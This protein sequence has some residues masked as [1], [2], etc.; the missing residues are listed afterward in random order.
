MDH[1]LL[2]GLYIHVHSCTCIYTYIHVLW[3]VFIMMYT[4][5][6]VHIRSWMYCIACIKCLIASVCNLDKAVIDLDTGTGSDTL[7]HIPT[8]PLTI[9]KYILLEF[10]AM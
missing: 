1:V 7:F 9:L 10:T 4:H 5:A 8:F 3:D 2:I 6:Q